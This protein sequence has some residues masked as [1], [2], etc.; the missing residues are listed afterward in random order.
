MLEP[1]LRFTMTYEE[2]TNGLAGTMF[3]CGR[4]NTNVP[5]DYEDDDDEEDD[6]DS[7]EGGED[8]RDEAFDNDDEG[9]V[10][11]IPVAEIDWP[12]H[13]ACRRAALFIRAR[14]MES[15]LPVPDVCTLLGKYVWQSK[16]EE[17]WE[18]VAEDFPQIDGQSSSDDS[19]L[20][21]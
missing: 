18:S 14:F 13:V 9:I 17:I 11:E 16:D 7:E 19:D 2:E 12:R 6:Y 10:T 8:D 5:Y 4:F 1:K 15:F 21:N 3:A 20:E